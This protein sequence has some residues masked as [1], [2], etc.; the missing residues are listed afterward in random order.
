MC[1]ADISFHAHKICG[2]S[3][4]RVSQLALFRYILRCLAHDKEKK[5]LVMPEKCH[6]FSS[7][8]VRHLFEKD[9]S[10]LGTSQ[11][12]ILDLQYQLRGPQLLSTL[13]YW[14]MQLGH[15]YHQS[16]YSQM[17]NWLSVFYLPSVLYL[18]YLTP[19]LRTWYRFSLERC[20]IWQLFY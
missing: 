11:A 9:A 15:C 3:P 17:I 20:N 14:S 18:L 19:M 13:H 1:L 5:I 8:L 7:N 10:C 4:L 12:A 6:S 2:S 16:L